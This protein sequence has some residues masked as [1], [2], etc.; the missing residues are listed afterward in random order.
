MPASLHC[1]PPSLQTGWSRP[2]AHPASPARQAVALVGRWPARH[3]RGAAERWC[4]K[5]RHGW[6]LVAGRWCG[7]RWR[8]KAAGVAGRCLRGVSAAVERGAV[9]AA[10]WGVDAAEHWFGTP[11][12]GVGVAAAGG[13]RPVAPAEGWRGAVGRLRGKPVG[14]RALARRGVALVGCLAVARW[15]GGAAGQSAGASKPVARQPL[16]RRGV[17]LVGRWRGKPLARQAAGAVGRCVGVAGRWRGQPL[18]R[19]SAGKGGCW[20]GSRWRGGALG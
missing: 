10:R 12:V 11:L 6:A 1:R 17:A 7:R 18:A 13:A 19:Q 5:P 2:N 4:G 9:G 8:S 15:G 16:V 3:W 20:R 14:P